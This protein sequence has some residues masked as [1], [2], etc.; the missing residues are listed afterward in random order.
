MLSGWCTLW[1]ERVEGP[2]R[3]RLYGPEL[4]MNRSCFKL[5]DKQVLFGS[6]SPA[7]HASRPDERE[8]RMRVNHRS[9]AV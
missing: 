5:A 8:S 7:V 1:E 9:S 3:S 4:A 6:P 2:L